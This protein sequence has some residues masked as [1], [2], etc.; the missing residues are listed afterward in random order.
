MFTIPGS[1]L[2]CHIHHYH[3]S[4]QYILLKRLTDHIDI[5]YVVPTEMVFKSKKGEKDIDQRTEELSDTES[6][7][8]DLML[9]KFLSNALQL[10]L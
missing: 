2:H 5:N 7:T 6:K 8:L 10:N 3:Y 9:F 4:S 1:Y